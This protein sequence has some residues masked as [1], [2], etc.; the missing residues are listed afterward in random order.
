MTTRQTSITLLSLSLVFLLVVFAGG[1]ARA[2]CPVDADG[3][4]HISVACGGD[5]CDDTDGSIFP[6]APEIPADGIDQDCDGLEMC[7]AD[8]DGDG[9]GD[10]NSFVTS[11]DFS[12][13]SPPTSPNGWDCD[14]T[15]AS[16]HPGAVD[17]P[18]NG[19]D[20][21]CNGQDASPVGNAPQHWGMLKARFDG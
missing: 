11:S 13:Q 8:Q 16:I 6:G 17:I 5:D 4:G 18:G 12:C 14:D 15:D 2:Q 9:W 20:E 21:D 3:D 19:I 10:P 1:I 7:Y